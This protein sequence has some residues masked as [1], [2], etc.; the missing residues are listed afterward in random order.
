VAKILHGTA[1]VPQMKI[2]IVI[3]QRG[4]IPFVSF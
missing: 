3:K 1:S 4:K 2:A